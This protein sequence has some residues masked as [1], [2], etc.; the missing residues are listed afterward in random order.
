MAWP[1]EA[2]PNNARETRTALQPRVEVDILALA[3]LPAEKRK[4]LSK[5]KRAWLMHRF[6]T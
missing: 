5:S 1:Q 3:I 2:A 6:R 4:L